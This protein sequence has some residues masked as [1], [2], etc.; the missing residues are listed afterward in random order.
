MLFMHKGFSPGGRKTFVHKGIR[1]YAS[2]SADLERNAARDTALQALD[3]DHPGATHRI[4][5]RAPAEIDTTVAVGA[6]A[7]G[8]C[9]VNQ[10]IRP[11][12]PVAD[13][14][15]LLET[16]RREIKLAAWRATRR[17]DRHL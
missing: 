7:R 10:A 12:K 17:R 14:L 9:S 13:G 4:G 5:W 8:V 2:L 6:I 3:G 16:Q 11:S 15:F 1:I